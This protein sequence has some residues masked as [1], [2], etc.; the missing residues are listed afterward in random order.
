VDGSASG[1][2]KSRR[3]MTYTGSS[4]CGCQLDTSRFLKVETKPLMTATLPCKS[5]MDISSIR[6]SVM[7]A[8][9]YRC[10]AVDLSSRI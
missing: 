10:D 1:G 2:Q 8:C 3:R 5:G 4:P 9:V 7:V 6:T